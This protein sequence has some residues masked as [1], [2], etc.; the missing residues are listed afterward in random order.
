M[1]STVQP[2]VATITPIETVAAALLVEANLVLWAVNNSVL[3]PDCPNIDLI[4]RPIVVEVT[5]LYG[6]MYDTNKMSRSDTYD[7]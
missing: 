5:T 1:G 3:M 4:Q 2:A 7:P 6:L